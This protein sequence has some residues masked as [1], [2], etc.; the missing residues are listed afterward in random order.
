MRPL[1]V[2]LFTL[3][4]GACV[5]QSAPPIG[6]WREHLPWNNAIQV[7][8]R[9][10]ILIAAT[11]Y[12]LFEYE[13]SSTTF[14]RWSKVNGLSD[15]GVSAMAVDPVSGKVVLAYRNSNLD[16]LE[17]DKVVNIPDIRVSSVQGDKSVNRILAKGN[18]AWLST[19]LGVI[20]VDLARYEVSATWRPSVNGA[21]IPVYGLA[22]HK[23][24]IYAASA[25]GIRKV[26]ARDDASNFRNWQPA[27]PSIRSQTDHVLSTGP[28][29]YALVADRMLKWNGSSFI[30]V[31][32]SPGRIISADT[33]G[34][35]LLVSEV[36]QGR[37]RVVKL[38]PD[39]RLVKLYISN[40]LSLPRQALEDGSTLWVAD[41]N[42]GLI[43]TTGTASERVFPNSPINTASGQMTFIG[44]VLWA[45]AGSVNE[46]WNYLFNPNGIYRFGDNRWEG[47]NLYVY[48]KI[49][50]MLDFITV[51]GQPSTGN[52][53]AGSYGGGLLEIT[54]DGKL[55]IFKQNSPL[56]PAI[57]DPGSYRVSGLAT[58]RQNNVWVSNF[59][60]ERNLH[61][62]KAD[63][64]WRSF[65]VPFF[66]QENAV[67]PIT[68]DEYDQKWIVS[69][70]GNGLFVLNS[71]ANIDNTNDDSWRYFRQ[72]RGLG[73]LPSNTVYCA[74]QDRNGFIWVGTDKG[75]AVITCGPEATR[76]NCDATIPIVQQD[77]F[78]G[79]L[80]QDEDVIC[81]EVDGANRKWVGT[82]NGLWLVSEQGDRVISRFTRQNSPLLSDEINALAMDQ[83][84]GELFI[85]TSSGICSFRGT[86]TEGGDRADNVL[87][88]PNPVPPG[89]TGTIGIR[90]LAA[91]SLVKI[92]GPDGRLVYQARAQGGQATWNG[93]DQ[94]GERVSSG[95]YLVFAIDEQNRER[96]VS[97]IFFIR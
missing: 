14:R 39:G 90:G 83:A 47:Y 74:V 30:P 48:P 10:G 37:G 54:P 21:S 95:A 78:A 42:N 89:F 45:T 25:E 34:A 68:I 23:D 72:G 31:Y 9:D 12:A 56:K 93:R 97:K 5:P 49:D 87:V 18:Q 38:D 4:S 61:V 53:Y 55:N 88:F 60:A 19:G 22:F 73:N 20:V 32:A 2:I 33:S 65:T 52:V 84:S 86:A 8:S 71:G 16:V 7:G 69:P 51:T 17:K 81:M 6:Q 24:S 92:T 44:G 91:N 96:M 50:S 27:D 70:K 43:S 66:H 15:I 75:I 13:R 41:Q 82:R 94:K 57:G 1:L 62:R 46:A 79:F 11:P 85:A 76:S 28:A 58:D 59:G 40:D 36:V 63:G 80:F 3:A 26:S 77:N 35:F 29:L 64:Q 67:G